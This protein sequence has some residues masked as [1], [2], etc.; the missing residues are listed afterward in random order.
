MALKS[1]ESYN[2]LHYIA[3][4]CY[5]NQILCQIRV[6]PPQ[7]KKTVS[8]SAG[9]LFYLRLQNGGFAFRVM[10]PTSVARCGK[11]PD[12]RQ[13][14]EEGGERSAAVGI[15]LRPLRWV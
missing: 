3:N 5:R 13:W 14:R 15:N 12:R 2:V 8:L 4:F 7:P 6:L 9:C 10:S 1:S 11:R